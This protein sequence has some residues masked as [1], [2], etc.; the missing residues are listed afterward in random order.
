VTIS[1]RI[2]EF[3]RQRHAAAVCDSCVADHLFL[4]RKQVNRVTAAWHDPDFE[5]RYGR[6]EGCCTTFKVTGEAGRARLH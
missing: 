6:C 5:R 4:R 3:I 2:R 1:A